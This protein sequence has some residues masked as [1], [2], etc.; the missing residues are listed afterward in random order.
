MNLEVRR[1]AVGMDR[2]CSMMP[3]GKLE[4]WG[5]N[6]KGHSLTC[7]TVDAGFWLGASAPPGWSLSGSYFGL[8][9]SMAVGFKRPAPKEREAGERHTAFCDLAPKVPPCSFLSG[10][11]GRRKAGRARG[12]EILLGLFLE[13]TICPRA[14]TRSW[15]T[16]PLPFSLAPEQPR[17]P[18]E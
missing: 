10:F 7:L 14:R 2:L 9:H 18:K 15:V 13:N 11:K 12:L 1:G 16:Q 6:P 4:G 8:L 17:G 3:A 5:W